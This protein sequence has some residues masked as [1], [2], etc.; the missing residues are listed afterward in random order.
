MFQFGLGLGIGCGIDG[1]LKAVVAQ[2]TVRV[3]DPGEVMRIL[4][5]LE[6]AS[7][8]HRMI[9]QQIRYYPLASLMAIRP[10]SLREQI[11]EILAFPRRLRYRLEPEIAYH[12]RAEA[13]P[14][15]NTHRIER[16]AVRVYADEKIMFRFEF[17]QHSS[18]VNFCHFAPNQ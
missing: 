15:L 6:P 14:L 9:R 12:P 13:L 10:A 4:R 11:R 18:R 2:Q 7:L 3:I 16:A 8:R 1:L 17:L 5:N